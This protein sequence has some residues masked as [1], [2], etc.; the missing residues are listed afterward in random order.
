MTG[1]VVGRLVQTLAVLLLVSFLSYGLIGLMPGDP[2]DLMIQA[3]PNLTSG[4][5]ARLKALHGI[6]RP[7]LERWLG[8]LGGLLAGDLGYSRLYALP[9]EDVLLPRL[10]NTL[11]LMI[12]SLVLSLALALVLG[13]VAAVRRHTLLDRLL[14]LGAFAAFSIPPF[15]LALLL[16]LLFAVHLGWLPAGGEP[17]PGAEGWWERSRYL[18]LPVL[19]LTLLTTGSFLRFVRAALIESL[20]MPFIR[21]ARAKG[22]STSQIVLR[23]ALPHAAP[24]LLTML[25]LQIGSVFSGALIVETVFA[26]LGLGKLVYDA[27]LGNDYNLALLALCLAA[28]V[29]LLANLLADLAH[30]WLDPRVSL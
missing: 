8:W 9:V 12:T 17:D 22:V 13:A 5:V 1:Y 24:P 4:D 7:I 23:H 25:A 21:T 6:D 14:N 28:M 26:Y 30:A 18:V 29:T 16:I 15:W 11:W 2:I 10:V 20:A 27:I 19:T 3:D